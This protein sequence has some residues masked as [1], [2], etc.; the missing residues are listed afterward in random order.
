MK[1]NSNAITNHVKITVLVADD[2]TVV[3]HGIIANLKLQQDMLVV[4][5]DSDGIEA[6][7]LIKE[8]LPDVVLL[9]LRMPE[10]TLKALADHGQLGSIMPADGG[11]SEAILSRF[12]KAGVNLAAMAVQLQNEG[13]KSFVE[14]WNQLIAVVAS[15]RDALKQAA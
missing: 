5:E 2:H 10:A 7:K 4:A 11:G 15:K 6:I 9:D 14:S 3:R 13:T 8:H 12:R 1:R